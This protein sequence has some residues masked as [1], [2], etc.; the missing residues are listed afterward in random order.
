[1]PSA[2]LVLTLLNVSLVIEVASLPKLRR[3]EPI[4]YVVSVTPVSSAFLLATSAAYLA[5]SATV[6]LAVLR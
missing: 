2:A 3:L 5:Y 1:V 4:V 6:M